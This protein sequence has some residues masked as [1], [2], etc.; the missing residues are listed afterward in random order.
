MTRTRYRI[1]ESE[2]PYFLT[3]TIVGWLPVFTRSEAVDILFGSWRYLQREHGL[4]VF[5]L[6]RLGEPFSS[7]RLSAEQLTKA[8]QSFKSY[9]A[10]Q[11][12]DLLQQHAAHV[13]AA[14]V[15]RP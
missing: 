2:F 5:R 10:R 4:K 7:D 14:S 1:F 12:V 3:G 9:T 13:L 8:M 6:C 11:I 15:A